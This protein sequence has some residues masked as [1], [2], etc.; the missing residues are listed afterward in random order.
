VWVDGDDRMGGV[1]LDDRGGDEDDP[2]GQR[3]T[4]T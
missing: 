4:E 1:D 2:I 3:A